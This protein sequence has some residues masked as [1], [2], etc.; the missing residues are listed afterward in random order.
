VQKCNLA[1]VRDDDDLYQNNFLSKQI[2]QYLFTLNRKLRA[3]ESKSNHFKTS[4]LKRLPPAWLAPR[5]C[6]DTTFEQPTHVRARTHTQGA[7]NM[8][9]NNVKIDEHQVTTR[10]DKK[11]TRR[12]LLLAAAA[13]NVCD[14]QCVSISLVA[15]AAVVVVSVSM[16]AMMMAVVTA[17]VSIGCC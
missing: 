2:S 9:K 4:T 15:A 12:L 11:R 7:T 8:Y 13:D 17:L 5:C 3:C 16:V 14:I 6:N 1:E 10:R